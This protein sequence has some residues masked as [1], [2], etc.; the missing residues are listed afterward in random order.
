MCLICIVV[1]FFIFVATA[2]SE[3]FNNKIT[4]TFTLCILSKGY[5][6]QMQTSN[7]HH[8]VS[9]Q[10]LCIIYTSLFKQ[11]KAYVQFVSG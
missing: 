5:N 4:A 7:L 3:L 8:C 11:T 1:L 10:V 2:V 6:L 9:P